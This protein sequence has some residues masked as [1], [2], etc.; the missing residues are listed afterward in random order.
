MGEVINFYSKWKER[1]E[2]LRKAI[3]LPAEL[4]YFM[5]DNGYDP[6]KREDIEEFIKDMNY[7]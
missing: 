2:R 6:S 7:E 5:Y 3:G 1:Q 4:W